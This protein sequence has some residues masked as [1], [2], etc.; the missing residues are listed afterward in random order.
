MHKQTTTARATR[1][2]P[3]KK[4]SYKLTMAVSRA[5]SESLLSH[6]LQNNNVKWLSSAYFEE[7]KRRWL[8]FRIIF[9]FGVQRWRYLSS[10]KKFREFWDR[11]I[12]KRNL[13][14]N[15]QF[16]A[17]SSRRTFS[18]AST[19]SWFPSAFYVFILCPI[20]SSYISAIWWNVSY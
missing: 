4:L 11:W 3:N 2:P 14:I 7:R 8:I 12:I 20:M 18:L 16:F 17:K 6:P 1:T 19:S 13:K 10:L 15:V 9:S 5:L